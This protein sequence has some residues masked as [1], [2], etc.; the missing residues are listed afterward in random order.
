[1]KTNNKDLELL[2]QFAAENVSDRD[3]FKLLQVS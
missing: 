3:V 1:M 2:V